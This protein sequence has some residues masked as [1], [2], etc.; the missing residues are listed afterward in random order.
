MIYSSWGAWVLEEA[1][2]RLFIAQ[3]PQLVI[4]K[5]T[6][7]SPFSWRTISI[8]YTTEPPTVSHHQR[9]LSRT[10]H[11]LEHRTSPVHHQTA[12]CQSPV[13]IVVGVEVAV[14]PRGPVHHRTMVQRFLAKKI[15]DCRVHYRRSGAH[16]PMM[17]C[18]RPPRSSAGFIGRPIQ[19][20][21][22]QLK[23]TT[24]FN[25]FSDSSWF[26][27]GAFLWLIQTYLEYDQPV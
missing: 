1:S 27:L 2:Y 14:G 21:P 17:R 24:F 26:Y 18:A 12:M 19:W 22:V 10:F 13:E 11:L 6:D 9:D 16:E 3:K 4:D 25:F 5:K 23:N 7:I 15:W 8:S 20:A